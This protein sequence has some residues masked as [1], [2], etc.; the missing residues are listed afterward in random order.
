MSTIK[1][2]VGRP[3]KIQPIAEAKPKS[4]IAQV[5]EELKRSEQLYQAMLHVQID[6]EKMHERVVND[7]ESMLD[8]AEKQHNFMLS[9]AFAQLSYA[10]DHLANIEYHAGSITMEDVS[11]SIDVIKR[12][13]HNKFAK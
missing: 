1:R 4:S 13:L 9:T 11:A 2:K 8:E 12:I 6:Y 7:F 3:A 5:R 10:Q